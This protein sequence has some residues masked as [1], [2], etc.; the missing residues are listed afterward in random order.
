MGVFSLSKEVNYRVF[1][2]KYS[3]RKILREITEKHPI[4]AL[5][6]E[7]ITK[8]SKEEKEQF[9]KEYEETGNVRLLPIVEST[10]LS[11]PSLIEIS[12]LSIAWSDTDAIVIVCETGS[13]RE[14]ILNWIVKIS[15]LQ[16]WHGCGYDLKIVRYHTGKFPKNYEDSQILLKCRKNHCNAQKALV[17]LKDAMGHMYG[18]WGI[19]KE[20]FCRANMHTEKMLK[21]SATDACATFALFNS[22]NYDLDIKPRVK[23][24]I[25]LL[26][27]E[28]KP[29]KA[30]PKEP[31]F[32]YRNVA[33]PLIE[34]FILLMLNGIA[35]DIDEVEKLKPVLDDILEKADE[36]LQSSKLIQEYLEE[37]N[38][39]ERKGKVQDTLKKKKTYKD[40]KIAFKPTNKIH[41]TFVINTYL[42]ANGLYEKY[43][44]AEWLIK[45]IKSLNDIHPMPLFQKWLDKDFEDPEVQLHI[46]NGISALA[47]FKAR[48][49][50]QDIEEKA[51]NLTGD[52]LKFNANSSVHKSE[53]LFDFLHIESEEV[54]KKTGEYNY[55]RDEIEK[56]LKQV[57]HELEIREGVEDA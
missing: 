42:K 54:S 11:H 25:D 29:L 4:L 21:Y 52:T 9:R 50:N 56:I 37:K 32:F 47:R 8:Y 45:D 5:D 53:F 1:N 15:N 39:Y 51:N 36:T 6:F 40:F 28:Q 49:F 20:D 57:E 55:P 33:K 48:V 13:I 17:G 23:N 35:I 12:H 19:D 18:D 30:A 46:E 34:D 44:L 16:I 31:D 26:P 24:P 3:A 43:G 14:F 2:S 27:L 10:G 38:E 41:R 22:L 7:T